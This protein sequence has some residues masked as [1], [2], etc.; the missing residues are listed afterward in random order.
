MPLLEEQA[1]KQGLKE[2][3]TLLYELDLLFLNSGKLGLILHAF[4]WEPGRQAGSQRSPD[5]VV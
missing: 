3:L 5:F 4:A 1:D 2:V